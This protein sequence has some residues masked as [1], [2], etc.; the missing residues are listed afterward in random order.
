MQWLCC[1]YAGSSETVVNVAKNTEKSRPCGMTT[2]ADSN[3]TTVHPH[4][5]KPRPYS[6][7]VCDKRFT[8]R[9][10]LKRHS[11]RHTANTVHMCSQCQKRFSSQFTLRRHMNI[12]A[13]KYQCSECSKCCHTSSQLAVHMRSHSGEKPFECTVCSKRFTQSL[14]LIHI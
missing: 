3:D 5:G 13:S 12:H 10:N 14:S 11:E 1:A 2:E 8:Q 4:D 6:C 9:R 7:T